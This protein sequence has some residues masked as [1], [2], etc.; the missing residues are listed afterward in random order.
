MKNFFK[1]IYRF[2]TIF[3]IAVNGRLAVQKRENPVGGELGLGVVRCKRSSLADGHGTKD[4]SRED[5]EDV[6]EISIDD[7]ARVTSDLEGTETEGNHETK[8][9]D[10]LRKPVGHTI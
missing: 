6:F 5:N 10:P 9:E 8:V 1:L 7:V 2:C 3:R 4:E